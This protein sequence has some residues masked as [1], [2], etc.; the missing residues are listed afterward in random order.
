MDHL[1][2]G[3]NAGWRRCWM[4]AD[5]HVHILDECLE[6]PHASLAAH[7]QRNRALSGIQVEVLQA[8]LRMRLI[9]CKWGPVTG[10]V[11]G[12]RLDFDDVRPKFRQQ[13]ATKGSGDP[14][15]ELK[16]ADTG[17][18][19][20]GSD[21]HRYASRAANKEFVE[22][23]GTAEKVFPSLHFASDRFGTREIQLT[24]GIAHH[25]LGNRCGRSSTALMSDATLGE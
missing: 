18:W 5:D 25:L 13:L 6:E 19:Q 4:I 3:K 8:P 23:S 1:V 21:R 24:H 16:D 12:G 15:G 17:K 11:T 22:A 20:V 2:L 9:M 7:M 10:N 14:L